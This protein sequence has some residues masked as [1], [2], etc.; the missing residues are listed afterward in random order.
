VTSEQLANDRDYISRAVE[1]SVRVGLLILLLAACFLIVRPF[2]TLT[3]WGIVVAIAVYPGYQK[4]RSVLG[5]RGGLAA[6]I[7]TFILL[8]VLIIPVVLLTKTLVE[9]V[10]TLTVRLQG[11]ALTIPPPPS[12]IESWPIIGARLKNVWG[13]ASTSLTEVLRRFAPQIKAVIPAL[14]SA[15]AEI[16]LTVVQFV[17][18]ILLAGALLANAR[19]GAK[20]VTSLATRLFGDKGPE[21]QELAGSTIRSVTNGILGVALIQSLFA[22]IGFIVA[23]IPGAGLWALIFLVGAVLQVGG[24]VLIPAVIY[25]FT[26]ASTTKAVAFLVWCIVVGVMDNLL[27]PLL[28]GRGS[29]V[30]TAVIFVGAMG[31][32]IAM[33]I[34]GLFVGAIVV[35]LSYKL[36]LAWLDRATR[37]DVSQQVS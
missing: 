15:S 33:G 8:A 12:G 2:L 34:I 25:M 14:L 23:G 13:L 29:T 32:F 17:F 20:V 6:V 1:V 16:G 10:H 4:L 27:K 24:L 22:S 28:L 7:C 3:A 19:S 18:S 35:S 31:G 5:G 9:G 30:P 11:G 36:C 21:L 37:P 26:I